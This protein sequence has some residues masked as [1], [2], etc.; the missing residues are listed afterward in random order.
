MATKIEVTKLNALDDN[1]VEGQKVIEI[2]L[3]PTIG[4][5]TADLALAVAQAEAAQ[6]AAE[7]AEDNAKASEL[8]ALASEGAAQTAQ[9]LAEVAEGNAKAS[10]IAAQS[11]EDDA[12]ISEDAAA[13]S[14]AA[15]LASQ[16]AAAV[17]AAAALA[18]ENAAQSS[19]D[20]AQVSEDNAAA[21][22]VAAAASAAAALASENA[23]QSSEDDAQISEDAAAASA[24]AALASE[25]AAQSSEDDAKVSEDAAAASAAAAL[26]QANRAE[27]E[28]DRSETEADRA[29]TIADSMTT[30]LVPRGD[31]DAS[32]GAFPTP[33]L[34][35]ERADFYQISVAGTM[36]TNKPAG[37]DDLSVEVGDQLYWNVVIDVWYSIDNTDQVTSVDG[38]KGVVV[39]D[40]YTQAEADARFVNAAGDTMTGALTIEESVMLVG[41]TAADNYMELAQVY[42][43][44]YGF[45]FQHNNAS[46]MTNLQGSTNQAL[47]LGDVSAN[48]TDV[49]LGVSL[50]EGA[51][52]W[53][54]RLELDGAGE[55]YLGSG[56]AYRTF[57]ENYHPNADKWTTSRTVTL[58][59][60]A[61][62]SFAIDGS[63]DVSVSVV[64]EDDSHVHTD[65]LSNVATDL[66]NI[67]Y[68][69][70]YASDEKPLIQLVG[71]D[72]Y[73]GSHGRVGLQLASSSNPEWKTST[74]AYKL[75]NESYHPN[76]DTWTTAR[77]ITLTGD[78]TGSF[79]MDGSSDESVEV[80]VVNDSHTHDTRYLKL[81]GGYMAGEITGPYSWVLN[82]TFV[83]IENETPQ[84]LLLCL[85]AGGNNVNGE[86]ILN[87]TSGN[88]QSA[89]LN[90]VVSSGS[91]V[92]PYGT[93]VSVQSTQDDEE[94]RLVT[95]DYAGDSWVAIKYVGNSYPVT[96][97]GLFSG[98]IQ[99]SKAGSLTAVGAASITNEAPLRDA[100]KFELNGQAIFHQGYH[101]NADKWT[102]SRTVTFTGD[103]TGSLSLD[104]S[105]NESVTMTVVDDSHNHSYV[106]G[107]F[108]IRHANEQLKLVD[109]T[110]GNKWWM[111]DHQNGD[112]NF[113]YN[114][115]SVTPAL[116]IHETGNYV[117]APSFSATTY[118][119][120]PI[121]NVRT[122]N[123][124]DIR[125]N[126]VKGFEGHDG[127]EW[128]AIGGGGGVEW[129]ATT[130]T[131]VVAET[132][133]GYLVT[134][135]GVTVVLPPT[136][137][138]GNTVGVGDYNG[139][140]FEVTI[141]PNGG[142]IMGLTEDF[143]FDTKNANI[144][145]S[146]VDT[147]VGWILTQ[148]FGESEA[149][150]AIANKVIVTD[151]VGQS[152]I[153]IPNNGSQTVDVWYNGLKLLRNDDY[154]VDEDLDT[155]TLTDPIDLSD[156]IV[157][158]YA[159]NQALVLDT[160][161][162]LY[163]GT[164]MR[165][166]IEG[167]GISLTEAI[168]A[169]A[170]Q[171]NLLINGD[172]VINQR[173]FAISSDVPIDGEFFVD[174]W[175]ARN[176]IGG[177]NLCYSDFRNNTGMYTRMTHTGAAV[178]AY[179]GQRIEVMDW[180]PF[181]NTTASV[182]VSHSQDC[183][184]SGVIHL[185]RVSD[186]TVLSSV[187]SNEVI[188]TPGL[189]T[190]VFTMEG[191]DISMVGSTECYAE[192]RIIYN[193]GGSIA[194][195]DGQ[196]RF[197]TAKLESG[198][199][200]TPFV[201]DSPQESLAKCQRYFYTTRG[202]TK[203]QI[204]GTATVSSTNDGTFQAGVPIPVPMRINKPALTQFGSFAI[205]GVSST[206]GTKDETVTFTDGGSGADV[207][208]IDI[209][210]QSNTVPTLLR[211]A[212]TL[213]GLNSSAWFNVDAE[214]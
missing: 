197:Y 111:L 95:V 201:P 133:A 84:Y 139:L 164:Q 24:A 107:T 106:N 40:K 198:L 100:T 104:G 192:F 15:A 96:D 121:E 16:N 149:P 50:K 72:A 196:Y 125:Y 4:A 55:L 142:K 101:P 204:F 116:V 18:S 110:D 38:K 162:L 202:R 177:T 113:R 12:Q 195:P 76:A 175:F 52:A 153:S 88:Y 171:P 127:V 30:A 155:V 145:F 180:R 11:S 185:R 178:S 187:F 138:Q 68:G 26:T 143:T 147:T 102:T 141:N 136:P 90:V 66:S 32:T 37:Q 78:A 54:K 27:T 128:G 81:A 172:F 23:A 86:F 135:A 211:G 41:N 183:V 126:P 167:D 74:A 14:E 174:R 21:S 61:T 209:I 122:G 176:A 186:D 199:L 28:A 91:S 189:K 77:T 129:E 112:L 134:E 80:T 146:Y 35:P 97:P 194:T 179:I 131:S 69:N 170:P 58:T 59:G 188:V 93:I 3:G 25:N 44:S 207:G 181:V 62:G 190:V 103:A 173:Q 94:Y 70:I 64:V 63:A 92:S 43:S 51:G 213:R 148:G 67:M 60:D 203:S 212:V 48:V 65:Y 208:F 160:T 8:A 130:G 152:V 29:Q 85:N 166:T 42:G 137:D 191:L 19:E 117:S 214:L 82:R 105:S 34:S 206:S 7:L 165:K 140:N 108:E 159:W 71:D 22:E 168:E 33:T 157:E 151:A 210:I 132:G 154:I 47:V 75:F 46:T 161:D 169:R 118:L 1:L 20:D 10:E 99:S 31:W 39:I 83:M 57:H 79:T 13:A 163:H 119:N 109:T 89:N 158:V 114:G 17:S 124:A 144:V 150:Q 9:T 200:A 2:I 73:F 193:N 36:T 184:M 205:Y 123:Q 182:E 98:R 56:A 87:R 49:L 5:D 115:V 120:L 45:T 6:A 156:D 53:T